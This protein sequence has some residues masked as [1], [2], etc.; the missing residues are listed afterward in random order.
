MMPIGLV[1]FTVI[2]LPGSVLNP[3]RL[4]SSYQYLILLSEINR[5]EEE[6][7]Q[8]KTHEI[9]G[10]MFDNNYDLAMASIII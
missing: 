6:W 10:Q 2:N 8:L 7:H 5:I 1:P 4:S 3:T 9:A